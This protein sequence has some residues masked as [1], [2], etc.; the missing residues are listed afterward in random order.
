MARDEIWPRTYINWT[1]AACHV[2]RGRATDMHSGHRFQSWLGFVPGSCT[3]GGR[4][5]GR[6]M[7]KEWID[8][9]WDGRFHHVVGGKEPSI[10]FSLVWRWHVSTARLWLDTVA[11]TTLQGVDRV[12]G[13]S[14]TAS[15]PFYT[16]PC[17]YRCGGVRFWKAFSDGAK[18][19]RRVCIAVT[20]DKPDK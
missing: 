16:W 2:T 6:D 17:I 20:Q 9:E 15:G 1:R 12:G 18:A 5:S 11:S 8:N 10:Y 13:T 7:L 4:S 14:M 19:W 3:C